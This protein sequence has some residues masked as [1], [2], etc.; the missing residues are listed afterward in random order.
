MINLIILLEETTRLST[1]KVDTKLRKK[2]GTRVLFKIF[3]AKNLHNAIDKHDCPIMGIPIETPRLK[4]KMV[5]RNVF[6]LNNT[7]LSVNTTHRSV[8]L[9][10]FANDNQRQMT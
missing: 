4:G 10:I 2:V 3:C 1:S 5:K 8:F 6:A 9:C 7:K